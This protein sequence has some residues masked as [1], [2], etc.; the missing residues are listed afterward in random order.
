M[1]GISMIETLT[2]T[3]DM[4][5]VLGVLFLTILLLV[6]EIVRVDV[7]ALCVMVMVGLLGLVPAQELLAGFSSNA[8]IA[9]IAIMIIGAGLDKAG[10][11][12]K[13][14]QLILKMSGQTE[15]R[16]LPAVLGTAAIISSFVQNVGTAA[17]LLPAIN[18]ISARTHIPLS[19]LLMP[20]GFC[21]L[22]GGTLTLVGC[23]SLIILNDLIMSANKTLPPHVAP[24]PPFALFDTTPIG[25]VLVSTGIIYFLLAGRW[26]LPSLKTA[27]TRSITPVDYFRQRYGVD[28]EVFELLVTPHSPLS[29]KSILEYEQQV[30]HSAVIVALLKGRNLRISPAR[31]VVLEPGDGFA[32]IGDESA[33]TEF[34]QRFHLLIRPQIGIFTEMLVPTQAGVSEVVIPEN[35]QLIGYSLLELRMRK[36]YGLSVLEVFRHHEVIQQGLRDLVLQSG[37]TLLVHSTWEDLAA[38]K[39]N[40]NFVTI[41]L[42]TQD[43]EQRPYKMGWAIGFFALSIGLVLFTDLRLAIA[44]LIGA[45]GMII[46]GVITIDEGYQRVSWQTV[47]LLAGLIPVGHAVEATGTAAW[48]AQQTLNLLGEMPAWVLQT[49][50]AILATVFTQLMSNVGTTVLLVPLAVNIAVQSHA[51]PAMFALTVALATS[52][53]FMLPTHQ[54]NALLMGP[55]GYRVADYLRAGSIMTLLFLVILITMMNI[56][57]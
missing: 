2:L 25:L 46:T 30:R 48:L 19:R 47:F 44:L 57:F 18:Q 6:T 5:L 53:S 24:M 38:L 55:G 54:V 35:S 36:T 9:I 10:V 43:K 11:M 56:I 51:D 28:G 50:L 45:L 12:A 16:I 26:I 31:D 52:N 15:K 29:G 17:L 1:N 49:V 20:M 32:M 39:D 8:V 23:S 13:L 7:A 4:V 14:A 34:A 40:K 22:L 33:I 41:T 21:T 37:D 27:A 3:T 42:H